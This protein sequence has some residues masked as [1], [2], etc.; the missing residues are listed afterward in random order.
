M[1]ES[2]R[3]LLVFGAAI[4]VLKG[5]DVVGATFTPQKD[6]AV[7]ENQE[8]DDSMTVNDAVYRW[9]S[10]LRRTAPTAQ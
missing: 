9:A 2:L 5:V 3:M 4:A 1:R 8:T 6:Q 10:Y 7:C